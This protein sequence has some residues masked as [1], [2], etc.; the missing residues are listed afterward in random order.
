MQLLQPMQSFGST[1]AMPSGASGR[2][3]GQIVTHGAAVHWLQQHRD[4]A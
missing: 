1:S 3:V 4:D 2:A